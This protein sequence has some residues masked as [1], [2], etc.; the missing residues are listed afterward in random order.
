M[1]LI[2]SLLVII[3]SFHFSW[4]AKIEKAKGKKILITMD[5]DEMAVGQIYNV[6]NPEGKSVGVVKITKVGSARA[7]ALL[8]KGRAEAGYDLKLRSR[9]AKKIKEPVAASE[10][11]S[12]KKSNS[13][14]GGLVGISMISADVDLFDTSGAAAGK[15]SLDGN[16]FSVKGLY[17]TA[18]VDSIWFR[19]LIGLEQFNGSGS[20][21]LACNG[22]CETEI[23]YLTF[24][25]WGRFFITKSTVRTWIGAGGSLLFPL[26][27]D[28]SALKESS[29][30]NTN[31]FGLGGGLDY[32][33]SEKTYIP[34][35]IEYNMYPKSDT[36]TASSIAI[37]AGYAKE[38]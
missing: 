25:F 6:M 12:S 27:K 36:V 30:T 5:G 16:G 4:A 29:I 22:K 17:D 14:I 19:G 2:A 31:I 10:K 32:F 34:F 15:T 23:L 21:N 13:Y 28:S 1:P 37:R 3:M 7:V 9:P 20:T 38:W 11:T 18:L 33:L 8:G 35:Q 26:T 24:D